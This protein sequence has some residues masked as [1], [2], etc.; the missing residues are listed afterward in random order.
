MARL[1]DERLCRLH[2]QFLDA[3]EQFPYL[4]FTAATD[5]SELEWLNERQRWPNVPAGNGDYH[6]GLPNHQWRAL[7]HRQPGAP[8][9]P[10]STLWLRIDGKLWEGAYFDGGEMSDDLQE[11]FRHLEAGRVEFERLVGLAAGHF[12]MLP[13]PSPGLDFPLE[14][15]PEHR[16]L[17]TLC[18]M[19][20]VEFDDSQ[21]YLLK[22][23][24]GDLFT[25]SMRTIEI[26]AQNS[27]VQ[28]AAGDGGEARRADPSSKLQRDGYHPA[29]VGDGF[30]N[31]NV[32]SHTLLVA[33]QRLA[34]ILRDSMNQYSRNLRFSNSSDVCAA[35]ERFVDE[36][37]RVPAWEAELQRRVVFVEE[38]CAQG[39]AFRRVLDKAYSRYR[40]QPRRAVGPEISGAKL[41]IW[42]LRRPA[43][44]VLSLAQVVKLRRA[45]ERG[46]REG[47]FGIRVKAAFKDLSHEC[48]RIEHDGE[49]LKVDGC[50]FLYHVY[51][52]SEPN[53]P[54]RSKCARA[55][56]EEEM[57]GGQLKSI[58]AAAESLIARALENSAAGLAPTEVASNGHSD[59]MGGMK[60]N[61]PGS[62]ECAEKAAKRSGPQR[63]SD[64][65]NREYNSQEASTHDDQGGSYVLSVERWEDL[66]I[67]IEEDGSLLAYSPCPL[68][69]DSVLLRDGT[70]L[71]LTGDRWSKVL[72]CLARSELGNSAG[73]AELITALGY[74]KAGTVSEDQAEF[75]EALKVDAR[76]ALRTFT[77]AMADLGRQL[78]KL[79]NCPKS[80]VFTSEGDSYRSGF[81]VRHLC[82]DEARHIRFGRSP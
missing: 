31:G 3:S 38:Q 46:I 78:R 17:E 33:Y 81:V 51:L 47:I 34:E 19:D 40:S 64:A 35:I 53:P 4:Y 73:K 63:D 16:W 41:A 13:T 62:R 65:A 9:S 26:L 44:D 8:F 21:E 69:G 76:R 79:V 57:G 80:Q 25:A 28:T 18:R 55:I 49:R 60:D 6:L 61:I 39:S 77:A 59:R 72:E 42:E 5:R 12:E 36:F 23:V 29:R 70:R 75:S 14:P 54:N 37:R 66:G 71:D 30:A 27:P 22:R 45:V 67:G 52:A 1:Q 11:Q 56:M 50:F 20:F 10:L 48:R 24:P 43:A 15:K 7:L 32:L 68:T 2:G 58:K 82:R 74:M